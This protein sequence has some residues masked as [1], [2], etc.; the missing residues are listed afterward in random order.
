[1]TGA[2]TASTYDWVDN[3]RS[4]SKWR[5]DGGTIVSSFPMGETI[6]S[7]PSGG[8]TA[9]HFGGLLIALRICH[10][11]TYSYRRPVSLG[12]HRL[13]LR[14][15]ES[16]DLRLISS[17]IK[18]TPAGVLTWAEDVFGNAVATVTFSAMTDVLAIDAATELE[19]HAS[20]WPVFDIAASA[21]VYPFA[22]AGVGQ[23]GLHY[24]GWAGARAIWPAA[25]NRPDAG[26]R[27][28]GAFED[29]M[30]FDRVGT[31]VRA[32]AGDRSENSMGIYG[33]LTPPVE[34]IRLRPR[35]L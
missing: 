8:D 35:G 15:R 10:R 20:A 11:T 16:R 17:E 9:M 26:R 2:G 22:H 12:P 13:M 24:T 7:P 23:K 27:Q 25:S 31:P 1:M 32:A 4:I 21:I 14:P 33:T 34:K 3:R 29:H 30:K 5:V 6:L 19:L 18:V 28:A